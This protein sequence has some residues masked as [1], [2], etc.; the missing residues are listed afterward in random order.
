MAKRRMRG[1]SAPA[2]LT[3]AQH[4]GLADIEAYSDQTKYKGLLVRGATQLVAKPT[5]EAL[6]DR[7]LI[8]LTQP[9]KSKMPRYEIT[10]KGRDVLDRSGKL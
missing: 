5:L 9:G 1:N 3:K 7:G 4:D 6:Q 10:A 2:F 8:A